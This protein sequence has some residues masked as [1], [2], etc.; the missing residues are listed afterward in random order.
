MTEEE[1]LKYYNEIQNVDKDES[2]E[3]DTLDTLKKIG[4]Y[5]QD[6]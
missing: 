5:Y 4:N 6:Y 3:D 1:Y 2:D